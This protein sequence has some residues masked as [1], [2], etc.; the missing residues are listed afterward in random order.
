MQAT[1]KAIQIIKLCINEIRIDFLRFCYPK[2]ISD[3]LSLRQGSCTPDDCGAVCCG[4]C[5]YLKDRR[6]TIYNSRK[7]QFCYNDFPIDE[8]EIR[9]LGYKCGY[10]W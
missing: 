4:S 7:S 5:K 10:Y 8:W 9:W 6:C 2:Y 1:K 3:K